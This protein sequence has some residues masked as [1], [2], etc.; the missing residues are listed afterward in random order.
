MTSLVARRRV[1][2]AALAGLVVPPWIQRRAYAGLISMSGGRGVPTPA[3]ADDRPIIDVANFSQL[4]SAVNTANSNGGGYIIRLANGTYTQSALLNIEEPDIELRSASGD[5]SAVILKG[6]TLGPSSNIEFNIRVD[7]GAQRLTLRGITLGG[8][9]QYS[10]L[11]IVG[12]GCNN[13]L[14]TNCILQDSTEHL[15]KASITS[16]QGVDDWTVEDSIFRYLAGMAPQQYNGGIDAHQAARWRVRR[17][18]FRDIA[19]PNTAACQHAINFWNA[20]HDNL[21][22]RNIVVDCDRGIGSGLNGNPANDGDIIR[23]NMVYHSNNGDP[24]ADVLIGVEN[25]TNAKVLGNTAIRE[26]GFSWCMEYRFTT[27]NALFGN[28]LTNGPIFQ[29]NGAT[30]TLTTNY[31]SASPSWFVDKAN[32]NLRLASSQGAVVN[33]GT[34]FADLVDDIDGDPRGAQCDIGAHEYA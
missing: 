4:A 2:S 33:Q 16:S 8:Y 17:N 21:W 24:F 1:L 22:E 14:I 23:N 20:S 26:D 31:T 28:N 9:C 32:G 13:G 25:S 3:P 7:T 30:A 18:V 12:G 11:Q 5:P 29:R 15:I 34:T 27:T 19:S 10:A 6:S